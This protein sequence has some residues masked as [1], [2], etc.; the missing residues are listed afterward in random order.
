[1]PK[2]KRGSK[3][4][5]ASSAKAKS[6]SPEEREALQEQ[7]AIAE[8]E[9]AA[10]R[11]AFATKF[12]KEK[13]EQEEQNTRINLQKLNAQ[14]R[15]I[16]RHAKATELRKEIEI[17]SQSFERVLDR[18]ES[19]MQ[20]CLRDLSEAESQEQMAARAHVQTMDRLIGF[21]EEVLAQMHSDFQEELEGLRAEFMQERELILEQHEREMA[22][23][24]DII[25]ALEILYEDRNEDAETEYSSRRDEMRTR[26]LDAKTTLKAHL[27]GN[28]KELWDT[29]QQALTQY[30]NST[31]DKRTEFERL[32]TKD[33]TSAATIEAQMRKLQQLQER[34]AACKQR[35]QANAR[36]T[37][38][39]NSEL[40]REKEAVS[41]QVQQLKTRMQRAR[42]QDRRALVKITSEARE[43]EDKLKGKLERAKRVLSLGEVCR[44]LETEEEKVL[45]FYRETVTEEDV[46][47][48][49]AEAEA[50]TEEAMV[51]AEQAG[52]AVEAF[53][54]EV[55]EAAAA[56]AAEQ[57]EAA[58]AAEGDQ[59]L[60]DED[61][62][63][64]AGAAA[65]EPLSETRATVKALSESKR[66]GPP[67]AQ[68]PG[69]TDLHA[70][71]YD[72]HNRRVDTYD[73]MDN[74]WKR[75][76]KVLL[77]KLAV[78]RERQMLEAE[79]LELRAILKQYLDGLSV[80]EEVL[81]QDNTLLIVNS[82]TNAP[83]NVP[84]GDGRVNTNGRPTVVD[85]AQALKNTMRA[86]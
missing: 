51:A 20:S 59:F 63:G 27:E 33:R 75:Y 65:A 6:L 53:K 31:A 4:K 40:Q 83:L 57:G 52:D 11:A 26:N 58:A 2:S 18:K 3:A 23:I 68:L 13:L 39:R 41:K 16:M 17:L 69:P 8:R 66:R 28:V 77:D 82:R 47:D 76:N 85:A 44:K 22:D 34:M 14:W 5:S 86:R 79:N 81:S 1:M 36:D 78:D 80:N 12:L 49:Q 43:C 9:E 48:L 67:L 37:D 71:A 70:V 35:L 19:V 56:K 24:K 62:E 21:Q 7:Q 60:E 55:E 73:A 10:N 30:E 32:R 50:G 25:Y 72:Q 54:A 45:P 15:T 74:F 29:F 46:D 61:A 42:E 64:S 84:V 38:G